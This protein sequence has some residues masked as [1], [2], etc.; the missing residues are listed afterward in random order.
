MLVQQL[1]LN[2]FMTDSKHGLDPMVDYSSCDHLIQQLDAMS[3]QKSAL[4]RG[5][6]CNDGILVSQSQFENGIRKLLLNNLSREE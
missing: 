2:T 5:P 3:H 4:Y 1:L 6:P